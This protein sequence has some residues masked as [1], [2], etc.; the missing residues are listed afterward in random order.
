MT[1]LSLN[2][3]CNPRKIFIGVQFC[4]CKSTLNVKF[5]FLNPRTN[6]LINFSNFNLNVKRNTFKPFY[7]LSQSCN[8][9]KEGKA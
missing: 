6:F 3:V 7:F 9:Y 5:N 8:V 1:K 4:Y 2:F